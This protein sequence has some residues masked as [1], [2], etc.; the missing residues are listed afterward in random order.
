MARPKKTQSHSYSH[1][2][3][4][5]VLERVLADRRLSAADVDRYIAEMHEE[6]SSIEARIAQ[7]RDAVVA[8][9]KKLFGGGMPLGGRKGRGGDPPF[10]KT[11]AGGDPPFPTKKR[12]KRV[13]A[14]VKA[15]RQLQGQYISALRNI[16]KTK[17]AP[18]QRI[19]KEQGREKAIA[20]MR[21]AAGREGNG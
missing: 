14:E 9:V 19:A 21:K 4:A 12:K 16:P 1:S 18:F 20:A 3:A 13:S 2:Q 15:S 10:P 5:Y 6:I 7:L 11:G 8:P 17:R